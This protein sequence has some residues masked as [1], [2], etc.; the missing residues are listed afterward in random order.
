MKNM[1]RMCLSFLCVVFYSCSDTEKVEETLI[2]E[3]SNFE[4]VA[5]SSDIEE[6]Y[7]PYEGCEYDLDNDVSDSV[8]MV[9]HEILN[10]KQDYEKEKF[11]PAIDALV[12]KSFVIY[13]LVVF[14]KPSKGVQGRTSMTLQYG[15]SWSTDPNP[16]S[17][18]NDGMISILADVEEGVTFNVGDIVILKGVISHGMIGIR[19]AYGLIPQCSE[20]IPFVFSDEE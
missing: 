5:D 1:I 11:I 20:V 9:L 18:N 3:T 7:V 19:G 2:P 6:P 17:S 16:W 15:D 12:G 13:S 4:S 14:S 8:L 10:K